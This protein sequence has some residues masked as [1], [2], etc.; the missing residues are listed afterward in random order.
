MTLRLLRPFRISPLLHYKRCLS[1]TSTVAQLKLK[2]AF[3]YMKTAESEYCNA[4]DT[5]LYLKREYDRQSLE[6]ARNS[7]PLNAFRMFVFEEDHQG[8]SISRHVFST[9]A[10]LTAEQMSKLSWEQ[11][12]AGR[13]SASFNLFVKQLEHLG[14]KV[15]TESTREDQQTLSVVYGASGNY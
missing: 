9:N 2:Q 11:P 1:T 5:W 6:V 8:Y 7:K 13:L 3:E 12:G 15:S 10:P 4:R 14:F